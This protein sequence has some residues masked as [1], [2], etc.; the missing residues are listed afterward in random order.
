VRD[1]RFI[2]M[3]CC[4]VWYIVKYILRTHE[5]SVI[6]TAGWLHEKIV[7]ARDNEKRQ[8][9]S[10]SFC[11]IVRTHI[12]IKHCA[13]HAHI[14]NHTLYSYVVGVEIGLRKFDVRLRVCPDDAKR[15]CG[16][17]RL[18]DDIAAFTRNVSV[19]TADTSNN[20]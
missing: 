8:S 11:G 12:C 3:D 9:T 17:F 5:E 7:V 16:S 18:V 10:S 15:G 20:V 1:E 14:R 13:R 19:F 4:S 6:F 2:L